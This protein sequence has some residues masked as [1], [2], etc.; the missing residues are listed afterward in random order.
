MS[1]IAREISKRVSVVALATALAL[2]AVPVKAVELEG[3]NDAKVVE[4]KEGKEETAVEITE[5]KAEDAE[6]KVEEAASVVE[7]EEVI[8]ESSKDTTEHEKSSY[9]RDDDNE[10]VY[11][12][13]KNLE[14]YILNGAKVYSPNKDYV[15]RKDMRRL[16][17]VLLDFHVTSLE[18]LQYAEQLESIYIEDAT[19][20]DLSVLNSNKSLRSL[21]ILKGTVDLRYIAGLNLLS[22]IV[23]EIPNENLDDLKNLWLFDLTIGSAPNLKDISGL[24]NMDHLA[25]VKINGT[26]SKRCPLTD[27]SVLK[28]LPLLQELDLS[29]TN[30]SDF[31]TIIKCGRYN[32]LILFNCNISDISKL[33]ELKDYK[34]K[35]LGLKGN[36]ISDPTAIFEGNCELIR[37]ENQTATLPEIVT[38]AGDVTYKIPYGDYVTDVE[39]DENVGKYN[40][41]T[42]EIT[43]YNVTS[44]KNVTYKVI[45]K[46]EAD[47]TYYYDATITQPIK[48]TNPI[49]EPETE[50]PTVSGNNT[51]ATTTINKASEE[52]PKT[53]DA[54]TVGLLSLAFA[55][56]AGAIKSRKRK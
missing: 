35:G 55:S 43:F 21:H 6:T 56:L 20:L 48:V 37:A 19:D 49:A 8:K 30:V 3:T 36:N 52:S 23:P 7:K 44:S 25:L 33:A 9:Y 17:V 40:P 16:Q 41:E 24:K 38:E 46:K 54:G 28:Y 11:F 26:E 18:G 39:I 2:Q 53:G 32:N 5:E 15:T 14:E 27:V 29:Y 10:R 47:T 12:E 13:D 22:L 51:Q 4:T 31:D 42:K 45:A 1:K 34:I 50:A